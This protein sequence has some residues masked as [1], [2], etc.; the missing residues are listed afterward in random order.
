MALICCFF[1]PSNGKIVDLYLKQGYSVP[2][3][4]FGHRPVHPCDFCNACHKQ[5]VLVHVMETCWQ[6]YK[7]KAKISA[8]CIYI[9]M[10]LL[11]ILLLH[12]SKIPH[13]AASFHRF[14]QT[15][16]NQSGGNKLQWRTI[17]FQGVIYGQ[18]LQKW[19]IP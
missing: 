6:L 12:A 13:I 3:A 15:P 2:R 17:I 8:L 18:K 19:C 5:H 7:S 1:K 16:N 9:Y 11:K 14:C 4:S 10:F